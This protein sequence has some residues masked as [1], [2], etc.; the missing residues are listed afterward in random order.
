[1]DLVQARSEVEQLV[2]HAVSDADLASYL[3]YPEV[4]VAFRKHVERYGDVHVLPT[5]VYFYG[6]YVGQ[7]VAV[8][9][10]RGKTLIIRYAAMSHP[11]A[12]GLRT[13]FFELN[14]QP[15]STKILDLRV[16]P[17]RAAARKADE[18]NPLHV[19]APMPGLVVRL[20]A[21]G[22]QRVHEGDPL[23]TLEAMKM[24]TVIYASGDGEIAS[25]L[26]A[27]GSRV[28]A[29]DLLIELKAG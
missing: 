20:S 27:V 10:E 15:R 13:V 1:M 17:A 14:G 18:G 3:M 7:E 28:A 19:A 26:V 9:L 8:T 5:S 21:E 24:Q 23:L 2:G 29:G 22:A 16:A 6:M 4:F 11:D 25:V 12:D